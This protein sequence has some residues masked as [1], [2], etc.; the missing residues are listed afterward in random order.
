MRAS[1]RLRPEMYVPAPVDDGFTRVV[2][3]LIHLA[4]QDENE[5]RIAGY[6]TNATC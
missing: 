3:G 2:H 4:Y 5:L 1:G 6:K